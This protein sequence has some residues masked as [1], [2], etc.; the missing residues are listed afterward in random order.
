VLLNG[1]SNRGRA[2]RLASVGLRFPSFSLSAVDDLVGRAVAAPKSFLP[3]SLKRRGGSVLLFV[4]PPIAVPRVPGL[5]FSGS[6][7]SLRRALSPT[8]RA[9]AMVFFIP[10]RVVAEESGGAHFGFGGAMLLDL[11]GPALRLLTDVADFHFREPRTMTILS[12]A[13]PPL[14]RDDHFHC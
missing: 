7:G 2:N 9:G 14:R 5:S 3:D 11:P 8:F 10:W 1:N 13:R 6:G 4:E 12:L